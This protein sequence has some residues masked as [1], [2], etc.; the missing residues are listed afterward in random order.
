MLED[1]LILL[2]PFEEEDLKK[3]TSWFN[4]RNVTN[5]MNKGVFPNTLAQQRNRLNALKADKHNIQ[6]AIVLKGKPPALVGSIGIHGIDWVHRTATISVLIG[7][8]EG[9]GK[10]IGKKSISC[11][12]NHAFNKMNLRKITGGMWSVNVA[13]E[14]AFIANGFVLEGVRKEQYHSDDG[15]IDALEYGLLKRSWLSNNH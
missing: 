6:F 9:R 1:D 8:E 12:V 14:E 4:D 11:V 7:E 10:G 13:C 15:Y 2:R 5:Q 3:W